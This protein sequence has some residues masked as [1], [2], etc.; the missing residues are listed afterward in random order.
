MASENHGYQVEGGVARG[1]HTCTNFAG[2][3]EPGS[4]MRVKLATGCCHE[5][6]SSHQSKIKGFNNQ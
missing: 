3:E 5:Q 4:I 1:N 6:K 2:Q